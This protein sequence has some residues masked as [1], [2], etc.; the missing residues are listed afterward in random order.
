MET[1]KK[2]GQTGARLRRV[3]R[4]LVD[5]RR[6]I[7]VLI[8]NPD[9][10]GL[11]LLA[12]ELVTPVGLADFEVLPNTQRSCVLLTPKRAETLK[13]HLYTEGAIAVE[14]PA[15]QPLATLRHLTDPAKDLDLPMMGPFKAQRDPLPDAAPAALKAAKLAGLLPAALVRDLDVPARD[16]AQEQGLLCLPGTEIMAADD[17]IAGALSPD[18]AELELVTSAAVPLAGAPDTRLIAFRP[19]GLFGGGPEHIAI[20]IGNPDTQKPTL[21]RLHSEC[22]TGD[23][24]GSLKCDC[25]DQLRGAISQMQNAGG[26]IVLYLAQEGRGIGL[27]NK[28][29]AYHL[30]DQGFDTVDAN[31]RLGFEADERLFQS[32]ATML[33]KLGVHQVRLMTNNPDKVAEL[34]NHG[35]DIVERVPHSF[36]SNEHNKAYLQTKKERSGHYL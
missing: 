36:P 34:K 18:S 4:F 3:D 7:P 26:G 16:W 32:A 24:L 29:R 27:M 20:I 5:V 17:L 15:D 22:F 8:E 9:G 10:S 25:G 2:E 28:L 6:G 19:E 1:I 21:V 31:L 33:Q 14:L 35:I 23:L 30:Q 11:V 12:A 13:I